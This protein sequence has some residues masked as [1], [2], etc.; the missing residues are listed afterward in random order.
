ME[1]NSVR[2]KIEDLDDPDKLEDVWMALRIR[3]GGAGNESQ[4]KA[5]QAPVKEEKPEGDKGKKEPPPPG[6]DPP[7]GP[8]DERSPP[9][10]GGG[11][12]TQGEVWAVSRTHDGL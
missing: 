8:G 12:P 2:V 5:P 6:R 9:G 11:P 3:G 7:K 10:G 4:T 1:W